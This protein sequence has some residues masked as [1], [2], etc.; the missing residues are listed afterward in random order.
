MSLTGSPP[1]LLMEVTRREWAL[2]QNR[3]DSFAFVESLNSNH[4][5][6]LT[7]KYGLCFFNGYFRN[8]IEIEV[9]WD[10]LLHHTGNYLRQTNVL[11]LENRRVSHFR[12]NVKGT[13]ISKIYWVYNFISIDI[14]GIWSG[15][16]YRA[17][18]ISPFLLLFFF[19]CQG[20]LNRW[21]C[22]SLSEWVSEW[23][24]DFWFQRLQ[25]HWH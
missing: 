7:V 16:N 15:S 6:F 10:R 5:L 19:N 1:H 3:L 12:Y 8:Q 18:I 11:C 25:W 4:I 24:R 23:V 14:W 21:P 17:F 2:L 13:V 20:Q 9:P 22:H